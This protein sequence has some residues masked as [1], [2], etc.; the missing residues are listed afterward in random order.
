MRVIPRI[1]CS[2]PLVRDR[3]GASAS[4]IQESIIVLDPPAI[5]TARFLRRRSAGEPL[6]I[7]FVGRCPVG[8]SPELDEQLLP[9]ELVAAFNRS[10]IDVAAESPVFEDLIP[11]DM[12]RFHSQPGGL[13]DPQRLWEEC[14]FLLVSQHISDVSVNVAQALLDGGGVLIDVAAASG[15]ACR[16][17]L[18]EGPNGES[19]AARPILPDERLNIES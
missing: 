6:H 8:P 10:G 14:R 2:C 9:E 17:A 16:D 1:Q 12:R 15:C 19:R 13:P 4:L 3:L 18:W 5:A 11:P 7:T